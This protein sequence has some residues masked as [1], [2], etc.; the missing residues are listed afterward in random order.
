T[1]GTRA[2]GFSSLVAASPSITSG[3]VLALSMLN[4]RV[5]AKVLHAFDNQFDENCSCEVPCFARDNMLCRPCTSSRFL[6]RVHDAFPALVGVGFGSGFGMLVFLVAMTETRHR[7]SSGVRHLRI[8]IPY[9][10]EIARAGIHIQIFEQLVIAVLLFHLRD[11][12]LGI[13]DIAK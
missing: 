6:L 4:Y 3:T 7:D 11:T 2:R 10:R 13:G 12:A 8:W 1:S 5:I 9:S